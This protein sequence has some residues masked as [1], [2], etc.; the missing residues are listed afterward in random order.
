MSQEDRISSGV[1][2]AGGPG[3]ASWK[4]RISGSRSEGNMCLKEQDAFQAEG[5]GAEGQGSRA[6]VS[7]EGEAQSDKGIE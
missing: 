3:K 1:I 6:T 7:P 2:W 5:T 4:R